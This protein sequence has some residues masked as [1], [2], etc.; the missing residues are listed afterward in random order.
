[1]PSPMPVR[2]TLRPALLFA[3]LWLILLATGYRLALDATD[4]GDFFT[5]HTAR[6]AVVFWG[7]S[8]ATRLLA[9]GRFDA[10]WLW[11]LACGAYLIHVAAA[12]EHIH[13]W[14]HSAAFDHVEQVSGFGPGIFVSYL[15]SLIWLEDVLWWW[16]GPNSYESRSKWLNLALHGFMAF[17]VFNGTV[18]YET[19]FIRWA[20]IVMF[21]ALGLLAAR[22]FWLRASV[23]RVEAGR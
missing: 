5:R 11:T 12:F 6:V 21:F 1:M 16:I 2:Q 14:S 17:I 19:G 20:S 13:D 3:G 22:R 7:L 23:Q 9:I 15:F 10:R 8:T 4:R 18:V